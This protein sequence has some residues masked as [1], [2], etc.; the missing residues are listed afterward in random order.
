MLTLQT[1]PAI[2]QP[3]PLGIA[4]RLH[5]AGAFVSADSDHSTGMIRHKT[6]AAEEYLRILAG[7]GQS[8]D[9][10]RIGKHILQAGHAVPTPAEE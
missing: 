10:V 8:D 7:S 6:V 5:G 1:D 3:L 4:E 2:T 9:C